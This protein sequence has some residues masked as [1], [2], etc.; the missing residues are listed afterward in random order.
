MLKNIA[1]SNKRQSIKYSNLI[2]KNN[3]YLLNQNNIPKFLDNCSTKTNETI[4]KKNTDSNLDPKKNVFE[5]ILRNLLKFLY[6]KLNPI[7]YNEIT[8]FLQN[9]FL[10]FRMKLQF[11]KKHSNLYNNFSNSLEQ[12]PKEINMVISSSELNTYSNNKNILSK[13][14]KNFPLISKNIIQSQEFKKSS[15]LNSNLEKKLENTDKNPYKNTLSFFI[16]HKNQYSTFEKLSKSRTPQKRRKISSRNIYNR[17]KNNSFSD[18]YKIK[19]KIFSSNP[20][21]PNV[22]KHLLSNNQNTNK[23][24]ININNNLKNLKKNITNKKFDLYNI[25]NNNLISNM[26]FSLSNKKLTTYKTKPLS[27]YYT[28]KIKKLPFNL[29]INNNNNP[30]I[31]SN[32]TT[33]KNNEKNCLNTSTKK[34]KYCPK[35]KIK[36]QNIFKT[37]EPSNNT[38]SMKTL[39]NQVSP[40]CRY[41]KIDK[42]DIKMFDINNEN[43]KNNFLGEEMM[44][45]IKNS[46]DDNLKLMF[47]FSYENFLSKESEQ[48]SKECTFDKGQL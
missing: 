30:D 47:N 8:I 38:K 17:T 18:Y 48:E 36:Y 32:L 5:V 22:N 34:N 3:I 25:N 31:I 42:N 10:N 14:S 2:Q 46:L 44:V 16:K 28:D 20:Y 37:K 40:L 43:N 26:K 19:F 35:F 41:S 11:G 4:H 21:N 13:K 15:A 7:L 12:I 27:N 45:K 24:N 6:K 39:N 29:I 1:N 33:Q 23:V 9:Q